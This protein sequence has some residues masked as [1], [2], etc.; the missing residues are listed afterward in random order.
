M[1]Y[2]K[3]KKHDIANGPG[4]RVSLYVS[5][6]THRCRGC[7]NPETWD[8]SYGRPFDEAV[9]AEALEALR[10]SYIRGLTL[11]GGEPFEP[12]NRP[13]LIRFVRKV[14]EKLPEKTVWCYT[15]YDYERDLLA[16]RVGDPESTEALLSLVDVLV[17]GEFR[18]EQK[19]IDLRFRG[20]LN[21]RIIDVRR[22]AAE[23]K[24][25]LWQQ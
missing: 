6:C 7:F 17:D 2:A 21:Q 23:G 22:S 1:N 9:E 18:E 19:V 5:G 12:Q 14:R 16:G 13:E 20:S 4:V 8:F 10:P 24:P 3:I 25:V 15:G 11:L